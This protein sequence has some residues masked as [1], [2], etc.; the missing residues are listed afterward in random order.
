MF[1]WLLDG[2]IHPQAHPFPPGSRIYRS[3]HTAISRK[4]CG[5]RYP[6]NRKSQIAIEYCYRFR[7]RHKDAHVFWIHGSGHTRFEESYQ[8]V[9]EHLALPGLDDSSQLT[10]GRVRDWLSEEADCPWL[11]VLDNVDDMEIIFRSTIHSCSGSK[12]HEPLVNW[13]PRSSV[14]SMLI[15][16]RDRRLGERLVPG[17]RP[18]AVD[19][20]RM[21]DAKCLLSKRVQLEDEVDE[22]LSHQLLQTLD[23]LPL[24]ITQ[25]AAFLAENEI[26]IAE[27]L[28]ILQKDDSE[29]KD[30]LAT[31]IYDP[32]RDS[33]LSNSILQTWKVSF[34]QIRMQKPLAAEIL[35][36]MAVLDRQAISDRLLCRGKKI[37]IDFL[38]AIGVLKAF[39][40]IKA[41]SGNKVF[42]THRLVQL[43]TQKWLELE[44]AIDRWQEIALESVCRIIP[45]TVLYQDWREWETI[46]PHVVKALENDTG[47]TKFRTEDHLTERAWLL[48]KQGD[49]IHVQQGSEAALPYYVESLE[50]RQQ[51]FA[52]DSLPVLWSMTR[53]A[54]AVQANIAAGMFRN[55]LS[56]CESKAD[57]AA[58]NVLEKICLSTLAEIILRD[59]EGD[60][61]EAEAIY[62]KLCKDCP[63]YIGS[64]FLYFVY[65]SYLLESIWKQGCHRKDEAEELHKQLMSEL[66]DS[67]WKDVVFILRGLMGHADYLQGT[68]RSDEARTLCEQMLEALRSTV[69]EDHGLYKYISGCYEENCLR[70]DLKCYKESRQYELLGRVTSVTTCVDPMGE[71]CGRVRQ[72]RSGWIPQA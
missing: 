3:I 4:A 51:F 40:M 10:L 1:H 63:P 35:S 7:S 55:I 6:L 43:A 39:S 56:K 32:S 18:I 19:P 71:I 41:E 13:L 15:T 59:E 20:F 50:L 14:G 52:T 42:S 38:T 47:K 68:G 66:T 45:Q 48:L 8:Q 27:Y 54:E 49:Y 36:L 23:F 28:E 70:L 9:A 69:G 64:G 30:F 5:L 11:L 53:V 60:Y 46:S 65:G 33:D 25:A 72:C 62:K 21:K 58:Y 16:T 34:D 44:G 26:S 22:A 17:Q 12:K 37:G 24:A 61:A 29:M 2:F 57:V 67:H 31:D